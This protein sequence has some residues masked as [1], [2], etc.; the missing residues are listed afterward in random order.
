[1]IGTTY[2]QNEKCIKAASMGVGKPSFAVELSLRRHLMAFLC[3][4]SG[5]VRYRLCVPARQQP[6]T[7]TYGHNDCPMAPQKGICMPSKEDSNAWAN[8]WSC[9]LN[10]AESAH[11]VLN[12]Y[13]S[14]LSSRGQCMASGL[15]QRYG[16]INT[17]NGKSICGD[18][19]VCI[20]THSYF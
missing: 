11:P 19:L 10:H 17:T 6:C 14:A 5:R 9:L 4:V 7:H 12:G 20:R 8:Y 2:S 15:L 3:L 1:M 18:A 13:G 16:C